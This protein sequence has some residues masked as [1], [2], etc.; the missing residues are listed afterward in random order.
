[1]TLFKKDLESERILGEF[2]SAHYSKS[3]LN[4]ERI[5]EIKLQLKGIDFLLTDK[6]NLVYK[7]DEKAQL[8]YLNKDLPTFA[9]EIDYVKNDELKQGWLFDPNKATEIYAFV[10]SIHL[11]GK[12]AEVTKMEDIE[13]C[14]VVFVNRIRLINEL[15]K[16]GIDYNL[17]NMKSELLRNNVGL[18]RIGYSPQFNFQISNHLSEKPVNLIVRRIF[19]ET[20]G[21]T[22]LFPIIKK[23]TSS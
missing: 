14:D 21:K 11:V 6:S 20:I 5:S 1:M 23:Q 12:I 13:S 3:N 22:L 8:H 16:Y 9:L 18:K 19:L 2:L 7:V 17:C 10:F 4:I 15:S